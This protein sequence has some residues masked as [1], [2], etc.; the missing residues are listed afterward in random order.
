MKRIFTIMGVALIACSLITSCKDKNEENEDNNQ[1][2]EEQIA[3]GVKIQFNGGEAWVPGDAETINVTYNG[4]TFMIAD[5][6]GTADSY[7]PGFELYTFQQGAGSQTTTADA[8]G[9]LSSTTGPMVC[10]YYENTYLTSNGTAYGDWWAKS[11]TCDMKAFDLSTLKTT[12]V[13]DANM[14]SALQ[15]FVSSADGY[16]GG[17]IN[18]AAQ[19]TLNVKAGNM[20]LTEQSAK[21]PYKI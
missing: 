5:Y 2:Q 12:F 13:V 18:A 17:D 9:Q 15:A 21:R 11:V 19:G 1:N 16:T 10:E 14:F 4:S 8:Q 20:P 3:D 6:F 7:V